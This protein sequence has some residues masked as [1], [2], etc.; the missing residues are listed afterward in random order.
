VS[1]PSRLALF[2]DLL[3]ASFS[4]TRT[5]SPTY[6]GGLAFERPITALPAAAG[7][8][9]RGAPPAGARAARRRATPWARRALHYST[10]HYSTLYYITVHYG[11][12]RYL[13]HDGHYITAH[14]I[15]AHYITL[16]YITVHCVTLGTTGSIL[17]Y[18]TVHDGTLQ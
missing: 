10:L 5:R 7:L 14:Y 1:D 9:V 15:T 18:I 2:D 3:M 6:T 16:R 11:T 12:L 13:G 8:L 17:R 4:C